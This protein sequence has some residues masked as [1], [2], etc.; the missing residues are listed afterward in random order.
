MPEVVTKIA[1]MI[2]KDIC[3]DKQYRYPAF[4]GRYGFSFNQA[5]DDRPY[6]A[7]L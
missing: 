6:K 1:E 7:E 5:V 4:N 2:F 3:K